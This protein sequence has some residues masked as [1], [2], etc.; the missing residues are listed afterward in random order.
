MSCDL[1]HFFRRLSGNQAGPVSGVIWRS[2][3]CGLCEAL[4]KSLRFIPNP[5]EDTQASNAHL[6]ESGLWSGIGQRC[7]CYCGSCR[8]A[9]AKG[10][11]NAY[12]VARLRCLAGCREG[13]DAAECRARNR[14]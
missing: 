13:E 7:S 11:A 14:L 9:A 3:E 6:T 1:E 5:D 2:S 4:H 12:S 10:W 8:R